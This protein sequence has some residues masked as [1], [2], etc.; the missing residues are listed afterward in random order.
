MMDMVRELE[1]LGHDKYLPLRLFF[2]LL[3]HYLYP[4]N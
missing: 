3:H 2:F 1:A 4:F